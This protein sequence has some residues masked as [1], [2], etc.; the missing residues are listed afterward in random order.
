[1][2]GCSSTRLL[3]NLFLKVDIFEVCL[4]R[5]QPR[6]DLFYEAYCTA[7]E[8]RLSARYRAS[9]FRDEVAHA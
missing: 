2:C 5:S 1:M 7:A 3:A 4:M 6:A 8:A 9:D